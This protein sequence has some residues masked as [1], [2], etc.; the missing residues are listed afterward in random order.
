M[1]QAG[2]RRDTGCIFQVLML[3]SL[4]EHIPGTEE[5]TNCDIHWLWK[6]FQKGRPR[7]SLAKPG[8]S[9]NNGKVLHVFQNLFQETEACVRINGETDVFDYNIG[10]RHGENLSPLL[11]IVF[12]E[13]FNY[14]IRTG[15]IGLCL[16]PEQN[17]DV[18]TLI[19][20]YALL[21][22]DDTLLLSETKK[23]CNKLSTQPSN[24]EM[25]IKWKQM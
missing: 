24:F 7:I 16:N 13:Y 19:K 4:F 9:K 11:F 21:Y 22:A 17:S 12:L 15:F 3:S 23:I 18:A 5:D 14:L 25:R 2:F 20:M 8:T 6:I 1:E 10:V